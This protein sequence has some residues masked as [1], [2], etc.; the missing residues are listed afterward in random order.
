MSRNPYRHKVAMRKS[1]VGFLDILG[2]SKR[3]LEAT[4]NGTSDELLHELRR[5]LKKAMAHLKTPN[6]DPMDDLHATHV[7]T[8]NVVLGVP[9]LDAEAKGEN[10]IGDAF[11][12][13]PGYQLEMALGGFFVRG[14]LTVDQHYMHD[15][16]IFG[17]GLVDATEL[18][19]AAVFP[20][21]ILGPLARQ[22]VLRQITSFYSSVQAAPHNDVILVDSDRRWFVHYLAETGPLWG[23]DP[24][25][26]QLQVHAET[27]ITNLRNGALSARVREKY[28]WLANY[29]N[30]FCGQHGVERRFW[31]PDA[32]FGVDNSFGPPQYLSQVLI[33]LPI[34]PWNELSARQRRNLSKLG[35]SFVSRRWRVRRG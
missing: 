8:D 22:H 5:T 17:P 9:L 31:V 23:E 4:A 33:K 20:R 16:L 6:L 2:F 35:V 24:D 13:L 27:I 14:G 30:W 28:V 21:M 18:E 3:V 32:L 1:V 34:R 7:F 12:S 15:D 29:H 19:V 25:R 10:E 26:Q 11:T